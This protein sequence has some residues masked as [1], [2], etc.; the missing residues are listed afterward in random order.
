MPSAIICDDDKD[1]AESFS[2]CL[3]IHGVRVFGIANNGKEAVDLY[4]KTKPD[5]VFLDYNMP[6]YDGLYALNKIKEIN[7][8][9]NII[10]VTGS[11]NEKDHFTKFGA[12][13]QYQK[14]VKIGKMLDEI[15]LLLVE[16]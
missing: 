6:E 8:F 14:P 1:L 16:N 2:E 11:I 12:L 4:K 13:A 9:A 7:I 5:Y 3:N 10:M 15:Q